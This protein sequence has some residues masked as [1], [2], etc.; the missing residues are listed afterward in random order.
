MDCTEPEQ[1]DGNN[2]GEPLTLLMLPRPDL[3]R[4]P[5]TA[6]HAEALKEAVREW[7]YGINQQQ[8]LWWRGH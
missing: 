4:D 6:S 8:N 7:Y 1:N 2:T 5:R 3:S